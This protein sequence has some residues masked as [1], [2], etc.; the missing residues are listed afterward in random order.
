MTR[1]VLSLGSNLGSERGDPLWHL[2]SAV[3]ALGHRV[4]VVS[5]V[6]R[7]PPW[8][9]VPQDDFLNLVLIAE[10]DDLDAFGW[11]ECCRDLERAAGRERTLRWG[12]RTLDADVIAVS[13][14][15]HGHE[16]VVTS[17]T[18]ELTV[19]H[20]RVAKRLFVLVPWLEIDPGAVLPGVGPVADLVEAFDVAERRTIVRVGRIRASE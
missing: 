7:T 15:T 8:G 9:P 2:T 10:D 18:D 19:P 12:P 20:P 5:S 4:R 6:Y 14:W 1:A 11:L 3:H 17:D 13:R 16:V